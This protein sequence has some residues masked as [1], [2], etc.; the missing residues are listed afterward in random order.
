L[1]KGDSEI[2]IFDYTKDMNNPII[3]ENLQKYFF[4]KKNKLKVRFV[5][6]ENALSYDLAINYH[7]S[8][9]QNSNNPDIIIKTKIENPKV[10]IGET[11]RLSVTLQ[12]NRY[13]TLQNPIAIVGIPS[14]L[15]LQP[16]QL[17]EL[18]EKNVA[19]YIEL[20]NGY[21][22]F[23]FREMTE[24]KVINLDLK[25]D[26]SG[27]FEA[28]AS[29]AYLYYNNDKKSWSLPEAVIVK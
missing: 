29:S 1:Y 6:V 11:V 2:A 3:F 9:P 27:T 26:V 21:I 17:R 12:N 13:E 5:G 25:A 22:V 4:D 23:Y 18:E 14:G 8:L 19:D 24:A 7:T 15:T 10:K 20:W 16:W 28:P